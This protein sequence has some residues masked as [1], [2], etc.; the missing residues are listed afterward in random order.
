MLLMIARVLLYLF[1]I[2]SIVSVS[3]VYY[4]SK[5]HS[6][7]IIHLMFT[8]ILSIN[9]LALIFKAWGYNQPKIFFDYMMTPLLFI[10]ATSIWAYS[11]RVER[12]QMK[13]SIDEVDRVGNCNGEKL[14]SHNVAQN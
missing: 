12:K 14:N 11:F 5:R 8:G 9:L 6:L 4:K 2:Y 3:I 10:L 1:T 7:F 13:E